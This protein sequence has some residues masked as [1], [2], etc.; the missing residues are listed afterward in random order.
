MAPALVIDGSAG[1]GGGQILRTSLALSLVLGQPFRIE[2]IRA[3]RQK[4]GLM[5]QHLTAVEAA[6]SISSA[7]VEGARL[8][9]TE[10][11]FRPGKVRGGRYDFAVGTAGSSTLVF[12]TV[13]PA[14]LLAREASQLTLRGG[15]HNPMAPPFD[16]LKRAFLPLLARMGGEVQ[17]ALMRPGFYPAGGGEWHVTIGTQ[18]KWQPLSLL[19][20]GE[21]VS[22]RARALVTGLPRHIGERELTRVAERLGWDESCL[23]VEAV[24]DSRGPGNVLVLELENEHVT[25]VMTGFGEKGIS[26]ESVA[27]T[28]IE[29]ARRYLASGVPAGEHLADQLLVPLA[30]GSGG[31]FKTM[32]LSRHAATNVEVI[33]KFLGPTVTVEEMEGNRVVHVKPRL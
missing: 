19:S 30:T 27:D 21:P 7:S 15:T 1:E 20:R 6:A 32:P 26:A 3:R 29:E 9:S 5:R 14:L 4:P 25:E 33:E 31:V 17:A 22:R 10:L 24:A 8:S 23:S 16:F 18:P 2:K 28:A 13:L 12:Q 11:S